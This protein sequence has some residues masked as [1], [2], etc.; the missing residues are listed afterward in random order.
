M[1]GKFVTKTRKIYNNK[2]LAEK[3]MR[4][5]F[6]E[7]TIAKDLI[8]QNIVEYKYFMRKFDPTT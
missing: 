8:H 4:E 7:F 3:V 5:M 2:E 6:A 1:R